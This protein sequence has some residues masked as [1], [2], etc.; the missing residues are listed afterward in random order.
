MHRAAPHIGTPN[1]YSFIVHPITEFT[2]NTFSLTDSIS[3][4]FI[5]CI[6]VAQIISLPGKVIQDLII[7]ELIQINKI[8]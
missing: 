3:F 7:L 4:S 5:R 8:L 6:F 1:I 2:L